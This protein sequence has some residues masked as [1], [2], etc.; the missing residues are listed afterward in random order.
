MKVHG[1]RG[2]MSDWN[3]F[4]VA[5]RLPIISLGKAE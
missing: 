5:C 4:P 1:V 3:M 2:L